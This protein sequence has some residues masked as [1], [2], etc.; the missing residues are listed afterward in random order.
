MEA[1]MIS[2]T[3][4][5]ELTAR[6]KAA[7]KMLYDSKRTGL[8]QKARDS[9]AKVRK[10]LKD[11]KTFTNMQNYS[12]AAFFQYAEQD[13]GITSSAQAQ[14][15]WRL[16]QK[17]KT[18]ALPLKYNPLGDDTKAR[19]KLW[20][21]KCWST[22]PETLDDAHM[23]YEKYLGVFNDLKEHKAELLKAGGDDAD[24]SAEDITEK[25]GDSPLGITLALRFNLG[26]LLRDTVLIWVLTNEYL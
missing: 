5:D 4:Q 12:L 10:S 15:L 14:D 17:N 21:A 24:L 20:V 26:R 9:I 11:P 23:V 8:S 6:K 13:L 22:Y 1:H 7:T 19:K 25:H 18:H 2:I 3:K 16:F